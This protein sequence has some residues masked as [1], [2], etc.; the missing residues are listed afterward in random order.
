[1]FV[2]FAHREA[3]AFSMSSKILPGSKTSLQD[4]L[5]LCPSELCPYTMLW[6]L[7]LCPTS[8]LPGGVSAWF[9]LGGGG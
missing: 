5:S 7:V 9:S 3:A 1:M 8:F 4:T 6:S 2:S